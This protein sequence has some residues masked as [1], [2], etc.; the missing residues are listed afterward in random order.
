MFTNQSELL[1]RRVMVCFA[2]VNEDKAKNVCTTKNF[3]TLFKIPL[4][5]HREP[6][7]N[8]YQQF[9]Q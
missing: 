1:C 5:I 3:R 6:E 8:L 4:V 2:L 9:N 7:K